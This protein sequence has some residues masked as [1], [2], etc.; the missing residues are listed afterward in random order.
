LYESKR[1]G[2]MPPD[3]LDI[4]FLVLSG[5]A[6]G[7]FAIRRS[8]ASVKMVGLCEFLSCTSDVLASRNRVM[9]FTRELCREENQSLWPTVSLPVVWSRCWE[10]G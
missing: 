2:S 1:L 3:T 5:R 7:V 9:W 8:L 6:L 10:G 4:L